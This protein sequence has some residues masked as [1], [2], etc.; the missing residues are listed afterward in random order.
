MM[1]LN[2]EVLHFNW[3]NTFRDTN[4]WKFQNFRYVKIYVEPLTSP[5]NNYQ[6][7]E[8]MWRK[9][10]NDEHF[11]LSNMFYVLISVNFIDRM[12]PN[13]FSKFFKKSPK[14][15]TQ[16]PAARNDSENSQN[17]ISSPIIQPMKN[18]SINLAI[19]ER[20]NENNFW[21][22]ATDQKTIWSILMKFP[23]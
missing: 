13:F 6:T 23:T 14:I 11:A 21:E 5:L 3:V 16:K 15:W 20:K 8:F 4:L 9:Q 17:Y 2:E 7:N 19:F 18:K 10:C 22:V 12:L 1:I